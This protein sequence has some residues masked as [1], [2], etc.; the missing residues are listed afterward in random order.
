MS[1]ASGSEVPARDKM[2]RFITLTVAGRKVLA[3]VRVVLQVP[4][5]MTFE[6]TVIPNDLRIREIVEDLVNQLELP[7][8]LM[9]VMLNTPSC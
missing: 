9:E 6:E 2:R 8:V 7:R 5:G 3:D 1:L 4:D